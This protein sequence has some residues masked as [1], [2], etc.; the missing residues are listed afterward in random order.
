MANAGRNT[1]GSQFF[2]CTAKTSWL[3]GAHVVFGYVSK[4]MNV[5]RSMESAG[6]GGGSTAP[7]SVQVLRSGATSDE[8]GPDGDAIGI[9]YQPNCIPEPGV[10]YT[11][12]EPLPEGYNDKGEPWQEGDAGP[13]TESNPPPGMTS[14][15]YLKGYI[16]INWVP[17]Q[18]DV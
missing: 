9:K 12:P 11:A 5:V 8:T 15:G 2:L 6:S 13:F 3:D 18:S 4:G 1:N 17:A 10:K 7:H 14:A 16:G